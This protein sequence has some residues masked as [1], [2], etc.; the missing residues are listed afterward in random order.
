[1]PIMTMTDECAEYLATML[2][3]RAEKVRESEKT[4]KTDVLRRAC[5]YEAMILRPLLDA[6]EPM[7]RAAPQE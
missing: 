2:R 6:L 1:M 3:K 4:A 5:R 7:P